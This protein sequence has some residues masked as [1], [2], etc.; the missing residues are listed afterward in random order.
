MSGL[1]WRA[2]LIA[3]VLLAARSLRAQ[4]SCTDCNGGQFTFGTLTP[5][6]PGCD[7]YVQACTY[8]LADCIDLICPGAVMPAANVSIRAYEPLSTPERGTI[9]FG[10]LGGGTTFYFGQAD[11]QEMLSALRLLGFRVIDRRWIGEW[12]EAGGYSPRA[13]ANR[14]ATLLHEFVIPQ[15]CPSGNLICVGNSGGSAEIAYALTTYGLE[16]EIDLALLTSGPAISRL[17]GVCLGDAAWT[18]YCEDLLSRFLWAGATPSCSFP[19]PSLIPLCVACGEWPVA[20]DILRASSVLWND[21]AGADVDY[22][23]TTV[24]VLVA[25]VDSQQGPIGA[26]AYFD[27]LTGPRRCVAQV[28]DTVH[29]LQAT[30]SGRAAIVSSVDRWTLPLVGDFNRDYRLD[31]SDLGVLLAN[32]GSASAAPEDGDATNDGVIDLS[33]LGVM[34]S[35]FGLSL[36]CCNSD[37]TV[38]CA[39]CDQ[40]AGACGAQSD[41]V[42]A[43]W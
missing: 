28:A 3:C 30:P 15:H 32:Y 24:H 36:G 11:V 12:T 6:M 8:T 20:E 10:T 38:C 42:C 16:T 25:D 27:A 21:G 29:R 43:P 23:R 18:S 14:Y 5:V 19:D 31:L 2:A 13:A 1:G 34:L 33:D 26:L 22:P 37:Q 40:S 4:E 35:N 39:P 41:P 17:D 9:V 7:P